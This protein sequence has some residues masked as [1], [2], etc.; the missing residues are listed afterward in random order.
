LDVLALAVG[1]GALPASADDDDDIEVKK[2]LLVKISPPISVRVVPSSE[3]I[4]SASTHSHGPVHFPTTLLERF[5]SS[6]TRLVGDPV[7]SKWV[8]LA[9]SISLNGY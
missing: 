6:W 8:A 1:E 4:A 7:F 3:L 9:I 5:M 2:Q